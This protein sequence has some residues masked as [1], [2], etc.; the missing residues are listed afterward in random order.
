MNETDHSALTDAMSRWLDSLF[1]RAPIAAS[2]TERFIRDHYAMRAFGVSGNSEGFEKPLIVS[3]KS[4]F[5]MAALVFCWSLK[6]GFLP[7][8][9]CAES[10]ELAGRNLWKQL[11]ID[12]E[13]QDLENKFRALAKDKNENAPTQSPLNLETHITRSSDDDRR[14]VNALRKRGI[15]EHDLEFELPPLREAASK[16]LLN[17]PIDHE[18]A[19]KR[20][21]ADLKAT[22]MHDEVLANLNLEKRWSAAELPLPGGLA[23]TLAGA[24][25]QKI[26][27]T[28]VDS[29][30]TVALCSNFIDA[31]RFGPKSSFELYMDFVAV[32]HQQ[33]EFG[34]SISE[35]SGTPFACIAFPKVA[36]V[37]E[38]PT[39][40]QLD[41]NGL[42]GNRKEAAIVY[43]DG[44]KQYYIEGTS[45]DKTVV[46]EP[47]T[48]AVETVDKEPDVTMKKILLQQIGLERFMK[49]SSADVIDENSLGRLYRKKQIGFEPMTV[50][51]LKDEQIESKR[52]Q[53]VS[54]K[55]ENVDD[56]IQWLSVQPEFV[57]PDE[58]FPAFESQRRHWLQQ[59]LSTQP[60]DRPVL[61]EAV[62]GVYE[63]AGAAAPQVIVCQSPWQML[64]MVGLLVLRNYSSVDEIIEKNPGTESYRGQ[65]EA[66]AERLDRECGLSLATVSDGYAESKIGNPFYVVPKTYNNLANSLE[67]QMR[68]QLTLCF[69]EE[70]L[71]E[72]DSL[73]IVLRGLVDTELFAS[74]PRYAQTQIEPFSKLRKFLWGK[75]LA[76][77]NPAHAL[78][79]NFQGALD[80]GLILTQ[81]SEF[82]TATLISASIART[83]GME[84]NPRD[85]AGLDRWLRLGLAGQ[86]YLFFE[87]ACF[88]S[89]RPLYI[90]CDQFHLHHQTGPAFEYAD[91]FKGYAFRGTP[92]SAELMENK[93][94]ITVEQIKAETNLE[95][96]SAM[97]SLYGESRFLTDSG[98]TLVHEDET[99]SLFRT[100]IPNDEPLLMVR[101][102]D[103]ETTKSGEQKT[104]Y[105]RVPPTMETARQAVAWT[106]GMDD[107]TEYHPDIE[108]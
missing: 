79:G 37:C 65:L 19:V 88:V 77:Y 7:I 41:D 104:Y 75:D 63:L 1:G 52:F 31:I 53:E 45:V 69:E 68:S 46:E 78:E 15:L 29:D 4:V 103:P 80:E 91:G 17:K 61:E 70:E 58:F 92:L 36:L 12:I 57:R 49:D 42:L 98:A 101:V 6:D 35:A 66:L 43:G 72:F 87:K 90:H 105:L 95:I 47:H 54:P 85:S 9:R 94:T 81:I 38:P 33:L 26:K 2:D 14:N 44:F 83:L 18:P 86:Y 102:Q 55:C 24:I 3:C 11:V 97:L 51:E 20:V 99:G 28:Q 100:E 21:V 5:Q 8:Y 59:V 25:R 34:R 76:F 64:M 67:A 106:F 62:A 10:K 32:L 96:R 22:A 27:S 71:R 60:I 107:V 93:S 39:I 23:M 89:E 40:W 74:L 73:K 82:Q 16:Q 84:L 108:T 48:I 30:P 50:I 13:N 56:A